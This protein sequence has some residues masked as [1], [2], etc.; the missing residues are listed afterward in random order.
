MSYNHSILSRNI[1]KQDMAD[2]PRCAFLY[3]YPAG[4]ICGLNESKGKHY[5]I[6]AVV[7]LQADF[8]TEMMEAKANGMISL[9]CEK[10]I[11]GNLEFYTQ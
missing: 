6:Q 3:V 4:G 1:K 8:S 10:K 5:F 7:R 9:K 11:T 2:V